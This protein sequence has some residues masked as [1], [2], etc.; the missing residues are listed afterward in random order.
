MPQRD[1]NSEK[2]FDFVVNKGNGVKGLVDTGIE[3]VPELYIV[4]VEERFEP[5]EIS[6][7][8]QGSIPVIDVSDWDDPKVT[9]SICEAA[10]K[11]GCFQII[12]HGVPSE[13][14]DAVKESAHRFFGLP[15]EERSKYW[16]ENSPT[17][18]VVLKTS[19][20]PQAD[21]F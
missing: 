13:V 9:E 4:P 19:F 17:D 2:T 11:W 1:P 12:N 16:P 10:G 21:C 18:T 8:G 6:T 5:N 20:A 3:T 15:K 14:L 7:H